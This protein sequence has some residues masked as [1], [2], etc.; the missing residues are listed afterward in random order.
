[1][2]EDCIGASGHCGLRIESP[3][4]RISDSQSLN[5]ILNHRSQIHNGYTGEMLLDRMSCTDDRQSPAAQRGY[6]RARR[7]WQD[8]ARRRAAAAERP[9]SGQRG[10]RRACDGFERARA[11]AR[12]HDSGQ[13]HGRPLRRPPHQH[14]R[15]TRPR[16]L[17]RR[18]RAH[19]VDG[20]RRDAARRRVGGPPAADALR[21]PQGARA[22]TRSRS[23]S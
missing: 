3:Q 6:R 12:H 23:S 18:G 21:A 4:S 19:V 9:V 5:A 20:G 15:H 2:I 16:R 8:H 10:R 14:R 11:R 13:E 7:S 1:M 22:A 17:W